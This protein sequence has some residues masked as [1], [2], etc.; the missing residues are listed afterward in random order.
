MTNP[1]LIVKIGFDLAAAGQGDFFTIGDSAKGLW[2]TASSPLAGDIL[3]DVTQYVRSVNI[4]RGR[5]RELD[6]YQAGAATVVLD[7]RNRYFD[8]TAGTATSPYAPSIVPRKEIQIN[9]GGQTQFTGQIEDWNIDFQVSGDSTA[10]AVASDAFVFLANQT[11]NTHTTTAQTTGAR[12]NAILSRTEV[13]WPSALRD[14]DTGEATLQADTI[15]NNPTPLAY[16]QRV[17][18][19]EPGAFFVGKDG[20]L[21]FRD[22]NSLQQTSSIVFSDDG[23]GIPFMDIGVQ[24][25]SEAIR[26][27]VSVARLGGGTATAQDLDS[28]E[29]YGITTYSI[30]NALLSTDAQASEL[31]DWIAGTYAAPLLRVNS[32]TVN[33]GAITSTQLGDILSLELGQACRIKFTPNNVGDEIDRYVAVDSLEYN[34]TPASQILSIGFSQAP[35][36]FTLDDLSLGRLDFNGLGW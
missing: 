13:G 11:I 32:V 7:N 20:R 21:T 15:S 35:S 3:T 12:I 23:T 29:E 27:K 17:A 28:Q 34:L 22:R 8:P 18:E 19:V 1:Q 26:N 10:D 31:A 16:I 5:S 33:L 30:T 6:Q 14:I 24:V 36:A 9:L 2:G 4:R 25:G